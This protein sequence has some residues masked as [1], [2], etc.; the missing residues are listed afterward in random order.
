MPAH[1]GIVA[2]SAEGA[3]LCFR[4]IC[5]EGA[6]LLGAH[7]H[8]EI[9]M[10][11]HSLA[12]YVEALDRGDM[13]RVADLMLAS[14][15]K[16]ARAG[17]D[18]LIC[19]DNTIHQAMP[20]VVPRSPLPWLHIADVVADEAQRCSLQRVGILGTSYLVESSVYPE[21][22]TERGIDSVLPS[23]EARRDVHRAI[24]EELVYGRCEPQTIAMLRS[25][26]ADLGDSGCDAVVLACTE[27]PLV[28]NDANSPLPVLDS[29]HVL[30]SAALRHALAVR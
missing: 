26:I 3:A 29:T 7:A 6:A 28:L 15:E 11:A 2:C 23:P 19:P 1:I 18:F 20:Y 10:H 8:P 4:T 25:V 12:E 5:A 30:A 16:L 24:M 21:R 17:A 13:Q 27:L 14:A 9:S 22:L